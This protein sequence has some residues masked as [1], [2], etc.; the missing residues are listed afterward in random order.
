MAT[1]Y[2]EDVVPND[3]NYKSNDDVVNVRSPLSLIQITVPPWV[4][5]KEIV[6]SGTYGEQI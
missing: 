2:I 6:I 5:N 1:R 4:N 3:G